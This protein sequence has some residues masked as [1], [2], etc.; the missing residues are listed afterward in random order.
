MNF[1]FRILSANNLVPWF[2]SRIGSIHLYLQMII[3]TGK[4]NSQ[5]DNYVYFQFESVLFFLYLF[6]KDTLYYYSDLNLNNLFK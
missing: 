1:L 2:Y 4:L 3:N 6:I 5:P